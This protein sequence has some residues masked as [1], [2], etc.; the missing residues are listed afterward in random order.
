MRT[1]AI[2]PIKSFSETA[3]TRLAGELTLGPRR[4]LVE[5]MC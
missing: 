1:V 3:K 5:A 4:A 2:L